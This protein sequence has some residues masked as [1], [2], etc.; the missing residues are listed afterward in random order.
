M[1][2]PRRSTVQTI[3]RLMKTSR[4]RRDIAQR[5]SGQKLYNLRHMALHFFKMESAAGIVMIIAALAA[6]IVANSPLYHVYDYFF[7][8]INLHVGAAGLDEAVHGHGH[9]GHHDVVFD[10]AINKS[11][12][13]WV[14]DG[15]MAIFFFLVGLEI[16]REFLEGELSSR[17]KA[18]LPFIAA[19]GGMAA[20]ALIYVLINMNY[21]E[22]LSGWAIPAA[23]DIAF[24]LG[25]LSLAGSRAPLQL[26]ILL[27]AIAVIDDL[28]AILIIAL[29]Y[30]AD[31]QLEP[32]Y[33]AAGVLVAMFIM[34]RK[35]VSS[36]APFI[37]M[38][39]LLWVAVLQSG[40]H[41]TLAGVITA[42]FIP[43]K[44]KQD[45]SF[46]PAKNLEHS[47]HY[48]VAFG[49]LP[50]FAFANAGVPFKGMGLYSLFE[51][52]TLGIIL[53]LVIGKPLGI[54]SLMALTIKTGICQM[55]NHTTWTQLLALSML[56]GIGFT[57]SLF[58]GTLAFETLEFQASIRLGV[59][60]GSTVSAVAGFLMLRYGPS[61]VVQADKSSNLQSSMA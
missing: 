1:K 9:G 61:A 8:G 31:L 60:V 26:K 15:L 51:P 5:L 17:A 23:T 7:H 48:W 54:F 18:T 11:V 42:L 24:A 58:I 53:G 28:G 35:G 13:H 47:L 43:M 2:K 55:P 21:P 16:K 25:A 40:I 36:A 32:L 19:I 38:G 34:S 49:I 6:L 22:N 27:T 14:N 59:L 3:T 10:Y 20:P 46:S 37:V 57:M 44:S 41:A 29:F 30:T 39:L 52:V 50:F 12:L 33:F 45:P 4:T 56:A